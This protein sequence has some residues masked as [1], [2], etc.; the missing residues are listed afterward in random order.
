MSIRSARRVEARL[1]RRD[2]GQLSRRDTDYMMLRLN[3]VSSQI[4]WARTMAWTKVAAD[5]AM[6]FH[7]GATKKNARASST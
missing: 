2:H 4:R 6:S 1:M 7:P 3:N 5:Q